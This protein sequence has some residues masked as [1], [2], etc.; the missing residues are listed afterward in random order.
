MV[1]HTYK[2]KEKPKPVPA[3]RKPK[4]KPT[5]K[6]RPKSTLTEKSKP[7]ASHTMPDGTVMSGKTH[8]KD[9][10]PV[11]KYKFKVV[12]KKEPPK[13]IKFKV[14]KK[15]EPTPELKKFTGLSKADANKLDPA[16]LFGMLPAEL[17][18]NI[19]TPKNTGTVV[20]K[21]D[22]LTDE[23]IC[24]VNECIDT[25]G[26]EHYAYNTL[27]GWA[28]YEGGNFNEKS[29]KF[30]DKQSDR[31]PT[32][33]YSELNQLLEENDRFEKACI[34]SHKQ[35]GGSGEYIFKDKDWEKRLGE[36]GEDREDYYIEDTYGLI[37]E[38]GDWNMGTRTRSTVR[39]LT[40]RRANILK[41]SKKEDFAPLKKLIKSG[42]A[43]I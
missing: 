6:P 41:K 22:L 8:T 12:K 14:K 26:F 36:E 31:L 18:K 5:P 28:W 25:V 37:Y 4:V 33:A 29:S 10:K 43:F 38:D 27:Q 24:L 39:E 32:F 19:L 9:S 15:K 11:K 7:I 30:F 17:R 1:K 13:K 35:M 34:N 23:A 3:P 40:T 42:K 20:G 21:K 2:K 16:K